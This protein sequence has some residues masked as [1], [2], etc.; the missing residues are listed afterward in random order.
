MSVRRRRLGGLL[1]LHR[2]VAGYGAR[3]RGTG[4]SEKLVERLQP[5]QQPVQSRQAGLYRAQERFL[6]RAEI[7]VA[8]SCNWP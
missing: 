4:K 1:Q 2:N 8:L 3:Q 6:E 5:V 7:P